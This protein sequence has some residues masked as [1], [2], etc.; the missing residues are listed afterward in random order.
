[1]CVLHIEPSFCPPTSSTSNQ[2][3]QGMEG[4]IRSTRRVCSSHCTVFSTRQHPATSNQRYQ[5]M[6]GKIRSIRLIERSIFRYIETFDT[7]R[8]TNKCTSLPWVL[9]AAQTVSRFLVP[10]EPPLFVSCGIKQI[11]CLG[12]GLTRGEGDD[13]SGQNDVE[14]RRREATYQV[15]NISSWKRKEKRK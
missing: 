3:C 15:Y 11:S 1:M 4:K 12:F 7:A 10:E 8:N 9:T 5:G 2:G 6:K 14:R 13:A